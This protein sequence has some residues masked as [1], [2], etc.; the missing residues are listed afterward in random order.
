MVFF[1]CLDARKEAK[2]NQGVRDAGQFG[3]VRDAYL[4][5]FLFFVFGLSS[6]LLLIEEK[7]QKKI[8][9]STEAGEAGRVHEILRYVSDKLRRR[10]QPPCLDARK[11]AKENQGLCRG[12]GSWPG[13]LWDVIFLFFLTQSRSS[14][15]SSSSSST[16]TFSGSSSLGA[17]ST[18]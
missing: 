14:S 9:A 12:R 6:F 4:I 18:V 8:K 15:S 1:S 7:N 5:C 2:E 13:T 3:L 11:E 10:P 16:V 17:G